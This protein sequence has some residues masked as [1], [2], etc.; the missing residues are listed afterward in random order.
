MID[1]KVIDKALENLAFEV[2]LTEQNY[3]NMKA[4]ALRFVDLA[5][6]LV[7]K[8]FKIG[9]KHEYLGGTKL[10]LGVKYIDKEFDVDSALIF[11]TNSLET[12]VSIKRLLVSEFKVF[13]DKE[14]ENA[15]AKSKKPVIE[16]SFKTKEG[17]DKFHLDFLIV[18]VDKSGE[19]Y[20]VYS[21][22]PNNYDSYEMIRTEYK[23]FND[24]VSGASKN[25]PSLKTAIRMMK[26][27]NSNVNQNTTKNTKLASSLLVEIATQ[28]STDIALDIIIRTLGFISNVI[29]GEFSGDF[30]PKW[31]Y[32]RKMNSENKFYA[33]QNISKALKVINEALNETS[34][35]EAIRKLETIF[36]GLKAPKD[37][38]ETNVAGRKAG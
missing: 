28:Q 32:F 10:N 38:I 25:N 3:T 30:E 7:S 31:D 11:D 22:E 6:D 18:G 15:K 19:Q 12:L 16:V 9:T 1:K 8:E 29:D 14:Y 36:K 35:E 20:F 2:K 4:T 37:S 23:E 24:F 34:V 27:W 5:R 13:A 21:D 26:Y 33:K 17:E